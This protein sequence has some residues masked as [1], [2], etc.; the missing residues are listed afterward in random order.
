LPAHW[1]VIGIGHA[2]CRFVTRI[3]LTD[4]YQREGETA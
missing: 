3:W 1:S 4:D 2:F